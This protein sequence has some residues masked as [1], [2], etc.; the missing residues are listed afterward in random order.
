MYFIVKHLFGVAQEVRRLMDD[1]LKR[2]GLTPPQIHVLGFLARKQRLGE[3]VIQREICTEC[4]GVRA[5]SGTNL[6]KA[7]EETGFVLRETGKDAREKVVSLTEKG[8]TIAENCRLFTERVEEKFLQGFT[9]QQTELFLSF[10]DQAKA[11]L[12]N[13]DHAQEA[14]Q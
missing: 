4:G 3:T 6:V 9:P 5:S 1:N 7:L 10:L 12:Q 2:Q 14:E 11:N 8:R 13:F